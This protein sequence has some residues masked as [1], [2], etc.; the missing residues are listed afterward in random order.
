[1]KI[2][3]E[4]TDWKERVVTGDESW[5]FQYDPETR[6]QSSH[7]VAGGTPP[8]ESEDAALSNEG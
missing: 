5:V 8:R 6:R 4:G 1:M 3:E 7:W 2:E